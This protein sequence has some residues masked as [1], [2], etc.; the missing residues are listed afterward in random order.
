MH[1]PVVVTIAGSDSGGGAGI[2]ADL[3]TIQ[4]LGGYGASVLTALT[5][6]N[7]QTVRSIFPVTPG[8]VREQFESVF[9]DIKVDVVKIGMLF[10]S[11]IVETVA[12]CLRKYDVSKIVLDPVMVAKGGS[13]LLQDEAIATLKEELLPLASL[14]TPNI[15]E[16]EILTGVR[17]RTKQD[18][19]QAAFLLLEKSPAVVLKGGHFDGSAEAEDLFV[20]RTSG[21][22]QWV[23]APRIATKNTHG[24]GCSYSAAIATCAAGGLSWR[25]SVIKARSYL[26]SAIVS[27]SKLHIGNGCG[28][29]DHGWDLR[30]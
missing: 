1:R 7:T 15:P 29:I 17:I 28:P 26:H 4:A 11:S 27:G 30:R 3:K 19:E 12:E 25:E 18:M 20:S 2:Q 9:D 22:R 21:E 16:A 10:S 13:R 6:Q 23:S 24:T 14:V 8:F 5:A